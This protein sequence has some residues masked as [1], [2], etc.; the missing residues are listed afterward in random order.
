MFV[1][2]KGGKRKGPIAFLILPGYCSCLNATYHQLIYNV[3]YTTNF[4]KTYAYRA[5]KSWA[6]PKL[7]LFNRFLNTLQTKGIRI[8]VKLV[9]VQ[10]GLL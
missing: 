3:T 1:Y 4:I 9:Y 8:S 6:W 10:Q 2:G 7:S 5:L